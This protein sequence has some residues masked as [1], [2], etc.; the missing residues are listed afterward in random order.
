MRKV[1]LLLGSFLA[2]TAPGVPALV[3]GPAEATTGQEPGVLG[4]SERERFLLEGEVVRTRTA[5]GGITGSLRATL[6][7]DGSEHDAHIQTIDQHKLHEQLTSGLEID[8]HDTY[9]NNVAA[10][11]LDRLLG[12]D[13]VPVTV[14]RRY[15]EKPAAYTWWVDEVIMTEKERLGR[16]VHPPDVSAWNDRMY[17]VRVFDQLIYNIDRNLGNLLVD[18][19]WRIWM[20]DHTRG[21]KG[22][23]GLRNSKELGNRCERHLLAALRRL[24]EPALR[25]S[26]KDLLAPN[27]IQGL[28]ARRDRI[29]AYFDKRIAELGE[30]KV[31]YDVTP[32]VT[33]VTSAPVP[34]H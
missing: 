9:R 19:H 29:V 20:I 8:F 24:D 18:K 4:D 33:A 10:Y 5:P 22:F 13:M 32:H 14:V 7:R 3:A 12:I 27:Q 30:A 16:Q 23:K 2:V 21:F 34:A 28:L 25:T 1:A 17:M 11:R 31:L 15:Q 6:R 26:M